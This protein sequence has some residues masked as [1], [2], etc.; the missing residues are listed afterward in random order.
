MQIHDKSPG[1]NIRI[2]EEGEW[3]HADNRIFRREILELLYERL[4]PAPQG[5]YL[6]SDERGG[7]PIE[8]A[9]A[10]F[11][12]SRVD[13]VVDDSGRESVLLGLKHLPEPETLDPSTLRVGKDN[14]LYCR[15]RSGRFPA[16]FSRPA[17]YQIAEFI[18]EGPEGEFFVE[19]DG[20]RYPLV[21][22]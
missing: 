22:D 16:R 8:V 20:T 15:I 1:S 12:I 3:Y 2:D 7:Y 14:V 9:D 21:T 4:Q 6:L 17:Y 11:V 19:I 5:G 10:P 13:R 18:R